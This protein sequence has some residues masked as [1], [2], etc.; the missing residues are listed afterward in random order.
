[1][2]KNK[3]S[4]VTAHYK[5]LKEYKN[6]IDKMDF[7]YTIDG[8]R[9]LN[10][11]QKALIDAYLKRFASLQDYLGAK[12]FSTL[13]D[14]AGI[15][16]IKMSEVLSLIEKEEIIDLDKWIEFRNVRNDLEHDYPDELL[17]ALEDLR[18]CIK[19][20]DEL[21]EIVFRVFN[22]VRNYDESIKLP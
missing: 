22:F 12:V 13:L 16:Y 21:E 4:K 3:L 18:F 10:V 11:Y 5:A 8:F 19:S 2:I 1:M 14:M 20:F 7:D 9:E 17:D 15:N 6:E